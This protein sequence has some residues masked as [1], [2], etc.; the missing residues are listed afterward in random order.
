MDTVWMGRYRALVSALV[1]HS[2]VVHRGLNEKTDI[3][4]GIM[5]APQEWQ[6]LEYVI[7]HRDSHFSMADASRAL[8]IPPSSFSRIVK[9]LCSRDLIER[10]QVMHNKKTVILRPSPYALHL[11]SQLDDSNSQAMFKDFFRDLESLSDEDLEVFTHA[12]NNLTKRLP[13]ARL[14]EDQ[15]DELIKID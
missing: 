6:T 15:E 14:I 7:E 11:Y 5:L 3:G 8:G 2:N 12:L 4:D 13:S 9:A 1:F 10:F